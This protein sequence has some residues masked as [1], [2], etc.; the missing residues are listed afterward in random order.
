MAII[1]ENIDTGETYAVSR[2][3]EGKHF[4]A[5]L[6]ALINSSNL[7]VNADRGQ[8]FGYRLAPE[9][10]ALLEQWEEDGEM[11]DKV[12]QFT[13]VPTDSLTHT[14]FLSYMLYQQELGKTPDRKEIAVRRENQSEY[15]A[16]VAALKSSAQPEAVPAFKPREEA[17][18]ESFLNG[19]LTGDAGGDKAPEA[20]KSAPKAKK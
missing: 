4:G 13:K 7:S 2:E 18:L 16:R 9:Q 3:L 12:T 15:E 19:D 6:S 1:F 11:I 20:P 17:S 14:E 8:D 10:Q 5:K